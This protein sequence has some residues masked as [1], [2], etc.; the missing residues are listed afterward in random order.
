MEGGKN[1]YEYDENGT[2]IVTYNHVAINDNN[3]F[4]AT[5][6]SRSP[7]LKVMA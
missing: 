1:I 5:P 6:Q 7:T 3:L 4:V 2:A